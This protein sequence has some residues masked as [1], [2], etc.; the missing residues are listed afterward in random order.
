[1]SC[2]PEGRGCGPHSNLLKPCPESPT[3]TLPPILALRFL[4]EGTQHGAWPP[5]AHD[6]AHDRCEAPMAPLPEGDR[7]ALPQDLK[8]RG[9]YLA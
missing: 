4:P 3:H 2:H 6:S 7:T 8:P 1:M 9:P 5:L